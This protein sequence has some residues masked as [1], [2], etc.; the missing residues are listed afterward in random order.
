MAD[1]A[2]QL[3]LDPGATGRGIM[4][5]DRIDT[6]TFSDYYVIPVLGPY[7]GRARW[8]RVNTGD[9]DAQKDT[10]IRAILAVPS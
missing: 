8:C 1:P 3:L 4:I 7:A 2:L 6:S 9:T 5:Q 10:A